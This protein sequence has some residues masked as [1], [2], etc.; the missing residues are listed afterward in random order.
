MAPITRSQKRTLAA[1]N[2]MHLHCDETSTR[3]IKKSFR[4]SQRNV[5][6]LPPELWSQIIGHLFDLE[7]SINL[8]MRYRTV[9]KI[10]KTEIERIVGQKCLSCTSIYFSPDLL[11]FQSMKAKY[12]FKYFSGNDAVFEAYRAI[13]PESGDA[14]G[15]ARYIRK[16][17]NTERK[18][19]NPNHVIMME[20]LANDSPIPNLNVYCLNAEKTEISCDWRAMFSLFFSEISAARASR[21]ISDRTYKDWVAEMTSETITGEFNE[22]LHTNEED[23]MVLYRPQLENSTKLARRARINKQLQA[24]AP[25]TSVNN[26][27]IKKYVGQ[28]ESRSLELLLAY[29]DPVEHD[30][31]IEWGGR[32]LWPTSSDDEGPVNQEV[33]T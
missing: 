25:E 13:V 14:K 8:W 12:R 7:R 24:L 27:N 32:I 28:G 3:R 30:K 22:F 10:F 31:R 11:R 5:P 23:E 15:L 9:C 19:I 17:M 2:G 1:G 21:N 4:N 33:L 29:R 18:I 6:Q 16:K 26:W 20:G